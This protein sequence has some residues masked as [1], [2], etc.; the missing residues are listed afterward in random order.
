MEK[1]PRGGGSG[2]CGRCAG[3][4]HGK[5]DTRRDGD[6]EGRQVPG[7]DQ[8]QESGECSRCNVASLEVFIKEMT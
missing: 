7:S 1:G 3:L 2:S 6:R 5:R 8:R 4:Q